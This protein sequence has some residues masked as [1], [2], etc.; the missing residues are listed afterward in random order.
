MV[1][2]TCI[3]GRLYMY[4]TMALLCRLLANPCE[5]HVNLTLHLMRYLKKHPN[6]H[7]SIDSNPLC[8]DGELKKITLHP[9]FMED[10]LTYRG[11]KLMIISQ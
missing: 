11:G 8:L 1:Q 3:F 4:F 6:R 7:I 10:S 2:W 5:E 9:D